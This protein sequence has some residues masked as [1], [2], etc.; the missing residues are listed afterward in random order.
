MLFRKKKNGIK[1][2][3]YLS[4]INMFIYWF[5]FFVSHVCQM[6]FISSIISLGIY[7]INKNAIYTS[8]ILFLLILSSFP[9][10]FFYYSF[11]IYFENEISLILLFPFSLILI[12]IFGI[13]IGLIFNINLYD[14]LISSNY[15]FIDTFP[16]TSQFKECYS[17]TISYYNLGKVSNVTTLKT[18]AF[19]QFINF[20]IYLLLMILT[21]KNIFQKL[22]NLLRVKLFINDSNITFSN[23][24][25]N[26]VFL[27]NRN[28][29]KTEKL[30]L[31]PNNIQ[32]ENKN[33]INNN[34]DNENKNKINSKL[35]D[36]ERNRIIEDNN[37]N[38]IPTKIEGLKK[39]YWFCCKK[40]IRAVNN[41]YFGLEDNEKFGLLGFNGNGK[42]TVYFKISLIIKFNESFKFSFIYFIFY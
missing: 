17:F 30:P 41:I 3:L 18:I 15:N 36:S 28:L 24:Q 4:G 38:I 5:S 23:E 26:E 34:N 14:W 35:I 12:A 20:G 31:L 42:S 2:L 16:M 39:T 7:I 9:N 19:N 32:N 22:I 11:S 25:I 27:N 33:I 6:F 1:H 40:N 21:E 13:L 8:S 29:V 37:K 10:L